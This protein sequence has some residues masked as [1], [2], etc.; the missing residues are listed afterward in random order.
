MSGFSADW[1]ALREPL[2]ARS[3]SAD[4]VA[5]LQADAPDGPRRIVDLATG[6]GANLRYLAPR[7]GGRQDWLLVDNDEALLDASAD[8]L[9]RWAAESGLSFGCHGDTMSLHGSDLACRIRRQRLDLARD[10]ESLDLEDLWLLTASALLDLVAHRWLA[11]LMN[12]CRRKAARVLFALTYDGTASFQPS[13]PEDGVVIDRLNR[14][15]TRDKGF[16]PALGPRAVSA[17]PDIMRRCGYR[18]AEVQTPWQIGPEDT[19]LQMA[20]VDG[21]ADAAAE[22]GPNESERIERWRRR[23]LDYITAH[24]SR[25]RVGHRDLLAWPVA[26]QLV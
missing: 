13:L 2:D 10:A 22:V 6:T 23:R 15:Q 18:I 1:L 24:A 9:H 19:A 14:H 17:A 11:E 5:R 3:R 7:L 20:L 26:D 4:L 16:G 25:L 21:W 12:A 8:R